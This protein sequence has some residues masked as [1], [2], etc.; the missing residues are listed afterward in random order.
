M[1][2]EIHTE[3]RLKEIVVQNVASAMTKHIFNAF[4][5]L[6]YMYNVLPSVC[7]GRFLKFL[8]WRENHFE[9]WFLKEN[10]VNMTME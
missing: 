10:G 6:K 5:R 3:T 7:Y 4:N 9:A 8:K 1:K 2:Y